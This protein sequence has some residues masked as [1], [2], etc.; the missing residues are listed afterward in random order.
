MQTN[1]VTVGVV[2]AGP[3]E[4][5]IAFR[6][7]VENEIVS[8]GLMFIFAKSAPHPRRI[9]L[10]EDGPATNNGGGQ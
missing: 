6:R 7:K 8:A 3:A 2:F 10:V 5:V 1:R 9:I 4:D